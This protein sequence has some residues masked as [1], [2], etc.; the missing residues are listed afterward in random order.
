MI[1]K[2]LF[3]LLYLVVTGSVIGLILMQGRG[4]GL[5]SAWGGSG[6]TFSTRRGVERATFYVTISLIGLFFV[7]SLANLFI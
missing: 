4:A 3:Q 7:L 2:T 5:G 6:E 1:F